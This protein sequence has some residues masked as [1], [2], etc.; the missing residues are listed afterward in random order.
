MQTHSHNTSKNHHRGA[1]GGLFAFA[2]LM[3]CLATPRL[4]VSAQSA[5]IQ[6][7]APENL[8]NTPPSSVNPAIIADQYGNVHVFWSEDSASDASRSPAVAG[9]GNTIY[10]TRWDGKSWTTPTDVLY[11]PDDPIADQV[12]VAI[13]QEGVLHIVWTGL[14]NIYYSQARALEAGS[15]QAWSEPVVI[16]PN[17]AR[18]AFES[19]VA[20][21]DNGHV[22]VVYAT[23]GRDPAVYHV[24]SSNGETWSEP[25]KLSE[26]FDA[27]ETSFSRVNVITDK[28]GRLHA[29][30]QTSEVNGYGQAVYYARSTDRG[31]TWARPE[32]LAYRG[33]SDFDVGWPYIMAAGDSELHLI[34]TG[35]A[36]VGAA[37][38]YERISTNGGETW[39]EPQHIITEMIGI[40]GYVIPVVDGA[41][42]LHLIINMRPLATQKVGIYYSSWTGSSWSPVVPL[43]IDT[44][45]VESAHYTAAVV[46]HGNEIHIVWNQIHGG[47][48]WHLRGTIQNVAPAQIMTAPTVTPVPTASPT[49]TAS[50]ILPTPYAVKVDPQVSTTSVN[51]AANSP[52]IPGVVAA[53][54]LIGVIVGARYVLRLRRLS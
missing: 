40:N 33:P 53:L 19:S 1:I 41:G 11:V 16:S 28:L 18:S 8:S 10:Y 38:R 24:E 47:E 7:S 13:D 42:H 39:S 4:N 23:R 6:W 36:A 5:S 45:A 34:Y 25:Q 26:P 44:S 3:A 27:L 17:S 30:W 29:V 9:P 12:A 15:A 32:Q 35:G 51:S 46:A 52:L 21:D 49:T 31:Q 20:V 54:I 37:G 14:T 2:F 22:H 48:I 50:P 43:V